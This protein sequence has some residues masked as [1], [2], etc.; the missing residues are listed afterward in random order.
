MPIVVGA[1]VG[2]PDGA[3]VGLKDMKVGARDGTVEGVTVDGENVV[4]RS[5]EG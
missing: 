2:C 1:R 3:G 5:L 4:T